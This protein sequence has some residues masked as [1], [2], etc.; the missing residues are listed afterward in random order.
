VNRPISKVTIAILQRTTLDD[1]DKR[2]LLISPDLVG[3]GNLALPYT[4]R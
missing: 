4:C 3:I 2:R 1:V